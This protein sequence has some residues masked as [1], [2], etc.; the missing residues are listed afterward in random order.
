MEFIKKELIDT[1]NNMT[2][3]NITET[4]QQISRLFEFTELAQSIW[5]TV[6][7]FII[8]NSDLIKSSTE[9]LEGNRSPVAIETIVTMEEL[10]KQ[11]D[12]EKAIATMPAPLERKLKGGFIKADNTSIF[13]PEKVIRTN[14]WVHGDLIVAKGENEQSLIFEKHADST[15]VDRS[16]RVE[17]DYCLVSK[18][19]EGALVINQY[20]SDGI[21]KPTLLNGVEH[22]FVIEAVNSSNFRIQ[23]GNIVAIA[24]YNGRPNEFK[25]VWF[26]A[27]QEPVAT[28]T[29]K[30]SSYYKEQSN[31]KKL[32]WNDSELELLKGKKIVIIG[33]DF[34]ANDF[35]DLVDEAGIACRIL[36]GDESDARFEAAVRGKDL[37]ISLSSHSS[38]R[39]SEL[40]KALAKK[41]SIAF[42]AAPT[43]ISSV[44]RAIIHGISANDILFHS[45]F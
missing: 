21:L 45:L 33:A 11:E 35:T 7:N 31:E 9:Q 29:P 22:E 28:P 23:E 13:V 37:I 36:S 43:S 40:A 10:L 34:R 39:S 2:E 4:K 15:T 20:F 30:P 38:H 3:T 32:K 12:S 18:T 42:R 44:K 14:G 8:Y 24:Y 17:L 1:I 16:N 19:E 27:D 6:P 26:Y 5:K 41:Y 25:I